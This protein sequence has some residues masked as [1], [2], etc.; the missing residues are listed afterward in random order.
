MAHFLM[1][2]G[3]LP[4]AEEVL[5]LLCCMPPWGEPLYAALAASQPLTVAQWA[6]V[7][8]PFHGLGAALPTVLA[9]SEQEAAALVR[10]LPE[11]D[12]QRLRTCALCLA[13]V[14]RRARAQLP[15]PLAHT[16]LAAA[17]AP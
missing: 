17:V 5:E 2:D 10:H 14:Q 16:L 7:P 8:S 4:A 13:R 6:A 12:R 11:D 9:R 3:A 1:V 15:I